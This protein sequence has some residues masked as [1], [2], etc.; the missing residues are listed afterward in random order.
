MSSSPH[1]P[2]VVYEFGPF[3]LDPDNQLLLRENRPVA[4][5][6]KAFETLLLLVRHSREDLSKDDIMQ[7]I[8]PDAFVEESNLSQN[9]FVLRKALGETPEDRRYIITL[10]G[11]GYRFAA[12][13]RAITHDDQGLV[14]RNRSRSELLVAQTL[15]DPSDLAISPPQ[16][17]KTAA[18]AKYAIVAA[19]ILLPLALGAA[20]LTRA[21]KPIVL[22]EKDS[23]LVADF[24]NATSDPVFDGTLRQGLEVQ[25]QQSPYLN[26]LPDRSVQQTLALMGQH[27]DAHLTP[28]LAREVCQRAGSVAV[29]DGSISSI[30]SQ[31]VLGLRAADCRT[32][33]VLDEEQIQAAKKE[34]VLGALSKIASN[35]RTRIGESLAAVKQHDTPL[36]DATTPSLEALQAFSL[37]WKVHDLQGQA[38]AISFFKR[39]TELDPKFAMAH[40]ALGLMYGH[41][42]ESALA[43]Q[44]ITQAHELRDR[45]SDHERF[46]I[47]AYYEG[48]A[49]GNQ[50]KAR[51]TCEAWAQAYPR[52]VTPQS[53]LAGFI[54]PSLANYEKAVQHGEAAVRINPDQPVN[55]MMLSYDHLYL[56]QIAEAENT[57]RGA[58]DRHVDMPDYLIVRFD[59]AFLKNDRAEMD[60]IVDLANHTPAAQDWVSQ[61]QAF[62]YAYNGQMRQARSASARAVAIAQQ[63]GENERAALFLVPLTLW[64][65]FFGNHEKARSGAQAALALSKDR[66]VLYGTAFA[67]I[68]TG[69]SSRAQSLANELEKLYPED[70][71]VRFSYLPSVRG[72]VAINQHQPAKAVELLQIATPFDLATP[73]SNSQGFFGALYPIYVRGQAFLALQQGPQAA[74]E[75][76]KIIDHRDIVI[77]DPVGAMAQLGLARAYA[78]SGDSAKSR[79]AYEG[80][81]S[82]WKDADSDVPVFKQAKAELA[83]LK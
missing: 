2:K 6:P 10:P 13:V 51:Q 65:G 39:A 73:R 43:T 12:Q 56:G 23:V 44:H 49:T 77:S 83:K 21:R 33:A 68:L 79:A 81:L 4:V 75:F 11:K 45:T 70:T 47:D 55:Y 3:R 76:Q 48:R 8:W 62:T 36:Q 66:E 40:A 26:L 60:R 67:S 63:A 19:V 61:H 27:K 46:F 9:I 16:I 64:E 29:L 32:G 1:G 78:L 80:F 30:G 74:A 25:L 15:S 38:A 82:L 24:T 41:T 59:I 17:A 18:V 37:A 14:I 22:G 52:D 69:D 50:E 5:T 20:F 42:G 54:Y 28:E 34:E 58:A 71:A 57:L 53:F 72:L 7:A 35:F 31:Y